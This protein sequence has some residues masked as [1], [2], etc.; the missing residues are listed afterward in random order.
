MLSN[1]ILRNQLVSRRAFLIG[2]G[3]LGL[4]SMLAARMFYMQLIKKDEYKTLSDKNRISIILMPPARG[5]IYDSAGELVVT[6]QPC[7]KLLLDKGATRNY[8]QQLDLVSRILELTEEQHQCISK[9]VKNS[10]PRIPVVI[11]DQLAW[12]QIVVIEEYK[13]QLSSI[14]IDIGQTRSYNSGQPMAHVTGYIGQISEQDSKE[15]GLN[16]VGG[17]NI[18]KS[19]LEKYYERELRGEFGY[20]QMEINAFGKYVRELASQNSTPGNDLHLNIDA[21]LQ[22]NI[23]SFLPKKGCSAIVMDIN[24]GNIL[25]SASTPAFEPNNFAK[26][27][28]NYWHNL[29][30]D[31]YKPLINKTVQNHYPPGSVFKIVTVL[32]ALECGIEPN[33]TVV[34]T[35]ESALGGNNFRCN[36]RAGHGR[37]DM[38]GAIKYSC[39]AYMYEIARLIGADKIIEVAKKFGFGQLT[40][41]DLPSEGAGFLP[42]KSWKKTKFK[43]PWTLGDSFNL[44]IGQGFIL[45]TPMQLVRFGAAIANNGKL[46]KPRIANYHKPIFEQ[47]AV[48]TASLHILKE[49]MYQAVNTL[50]GTAYYSRILA[51]KQ[52]FAGKTG[53]AQVQSKASVDDDLSRESIAWEKRNHA[54]FIGFGPYHEPK[55]SIL[56]F[57]DHGGGG[58]RAAAPIASRILNEVY[59]KYG[60]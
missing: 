38:F 6:N 9:K 53:T 35:G 30:T 24:N 3:K 21:E 13:L 49:A 11:T 27:S 48:D 37:L 34:C 26:L 39:N 4:L 8:Q 44:A 14:F 19:G 7:F 57:V 5:K 32:A 20:K 58:G 16:N 51:E 23:W 33:K 45:A 15:L 50:G 59:L 1:E 17:F 46:Y 60:V 22:K 56:V 47:V 43:S 28:Q 40:G 41:V 52:Q 31:P 55:Y 10:S 36:A 18:G 42:S 29:I 12:S 54:T 2:I 25:V